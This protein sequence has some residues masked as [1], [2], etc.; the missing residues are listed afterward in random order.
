MKSGICPKCGSNEVLNNLHIHGGEGHPP[1]VDIMELE[2]E[3]RPCIWS[4]K[5]NKVNSMRMFVV[6]VVS[7]NF[8]LKI[9][10]PC[11][12]VVKKHTSVHRELS[13]SLRGEVFV[14]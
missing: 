8:M 2:P 9:T 10:R 14:L 6:H 11:M 7:L 12:K 13:A 1:Y 5:T 3:K 4:P